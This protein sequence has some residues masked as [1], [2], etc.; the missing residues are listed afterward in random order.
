[1]KPNPK[2]GNTLCFS[3]V[4]PKK[5][6]HSFIF[7]LDHSFFILFSFEQVIMIFTRRIAIFLAFLSG[8][9][10]ASLRAPQADA[11]THEDG[12]LKFDTMV[13]FRSWMER[14]GKY[15]DST[16]EQSLRLNIWMDNHGT[17]LMLLFTL[18]TTRFLLGASFAA[19]AIFIVDRFSSR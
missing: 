7:F 13:L 1:M 9:T 4:V 8:A 17:L 10:A 2:I 15:Y 6:R 19:I 14:H 18:I 3:W 5:R 11:L 16:E 12:T